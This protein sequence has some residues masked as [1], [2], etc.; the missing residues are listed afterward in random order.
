MKIR[1]V[2]HLATAAGLL[3][4][5]ACSESTSP[6]SLVNQAT[7][8]SDVASSAGNA[9]AL[10]VADL[11][12]NELAAAL[13][14]PIATAPAAVNGDS[15]SYVRTRTCFDGT[16]ASVP[17][18]PLSNVRKIATHVLFSGFR[19]DTAADGAIFSGVVH[20]VADDTLTRNFTNTTETS[21]THS[22]VA[23]GGDTSSFV[24]PN[25]TRTYDEAGSDSVEAVTWNLPRL[26]NPF[27]VS[28]KIVR[29]V[30]VH[31][32]FK[33]AT[34][35]STTDVTKRVEVDFPAD[36]QGNVVLKIDNKTCNLNLVTHH[37]SNCQ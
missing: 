34:R 8:T 12:G 1:T 4:L 21:R 9:V 13:P 29:N 18:S 22:G 10:N 32:T 6:A 2:L 3:G 37:V 11:S 31:A 26:N 14:S 5:G 17:C 28:G 35:S 23:I 7:L 19:N 15:I 30:T 36:A 16:G 25:V 27:P 33:D 24:G 20:R